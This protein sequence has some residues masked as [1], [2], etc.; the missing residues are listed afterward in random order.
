[1]Q[2]KQLGRK[3]SG[4]P[5]FELVPEDR[6]D[7]E[8]YK[9]R[10]EFSDEHGGNGGI[11]GRAEDII[12]SDTPGA[13]S[14]WSGS[15]TSRPSTPT[16]GATKRGLATTGPYANQPAVSYDSQKDPEIGEFDP[17][18]GHRNNSQINLV[19]GAADM[20][21]VTPE[22]TR[23]ER[24]ERRVPGFLRGGPQGYGGLPQEEEDHDPMAFDY[25]RSRR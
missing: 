6:L 12:R 14:M 8:H 1:M 22:R 11:Y 18:F 4:V 23:D 16:F 25:F 15:D 5:G 3:A 19:H 24:P 2:P 20:S 13:Q 9:G 10:A 7:F 21:V 17:I